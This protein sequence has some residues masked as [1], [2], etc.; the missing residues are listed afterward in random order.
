MVAPVCRSALLALAVAPR[1]WQY[2]WVKRCCVL[3][4]I[5]EFRDHPSQVIVVFC[6]VV[7]P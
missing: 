7:I 6:Y 3:I 1:A 4:V 2:S 5:R